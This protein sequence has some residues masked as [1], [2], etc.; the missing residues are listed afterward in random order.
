MLVDKRSTV[1]LLLRPVIYIISVCKTESKI[2]RRFG[3]KSINSMIVTEKHL[4]KL[5]KNILA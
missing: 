1:R 4:E 3:T 5:H 2:Q